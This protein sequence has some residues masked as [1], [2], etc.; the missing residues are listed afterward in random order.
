MII[1]TLSEEE[2]LKELTS[3]Y[4]WIYEQ[5][6]RFAKKKIEVAKRCGLSQVIGWSVDFQDSP[7]HNKWHAHIDIDMRLKNPWM[8][9]FCCEVESEE[10]GTKD[11]YILRGHSIKD[12]YFIK[13]TSH[14]LKRQGERGDVLDN[15]DNKRE[16]ASLLIHRSET[17]VLMRYMEF[18][19]VEWL[20][21]LKLTEE[22]SEDHAYILITM[23][24]IYFC[25]LTPKGNVICKTYIT[26]GMGFS[27][28]EIKEDKSALSFKDD[29][30]LYSYMGMLIHMAHNQ[31]MYD[32]KD[33]EKFFSNSD[34]SIEDIIESDYSKSQIKI[35]KP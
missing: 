32:K 19:K 34:M 6:R 12:P 15:N 31:S 21:K 9:T 33:V 11:Y 25:Y 35:L 4:K 8:G 3:D 22:Y 26:P 28:I 16:I 13:F 30:G 5:S 7:S 27:N 17:I 24:G 14:V 10:F 20:H 2:V 23:R 18:K 29:E 1:G